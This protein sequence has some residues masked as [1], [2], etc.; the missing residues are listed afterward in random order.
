MIKISFLSAFLVLVYYQVRSQTIS[1]EEQ[2]DLTLLS[3]DSLILYQFNIDNS[4]RMIY[5]IDYKNSR[6]ILP[7]ELGLVM[8]DRHGWTIP[9]WYDSL[10]YVSHSYSRTD[11]TWQPLYGEQAQIRDHFHQLT[12]RLQHYSKPEIYLEILIRAYNEGIAFAYHFPEQLKLQTIHIESE[13]TTFTLPSE[14]NLW[15]TNRAQGEYEQISFSEWKLPS[16]RPLTVVLPSG[17]FAAITEA[18]LVNYSRAML[19]QKNPGENVLHMILDSPVIETSPFTTPWRVIMLGDR[20][21][22]LLDNNYLLLNLND[23]NKIE[24]TEWIRP[25]KAIREMSLSTEGGLKLVDFAVQQG[26]DFIHLDAG[27]YGYEYSHLA[28]ARTVSVDPRRNPDGNLDLPKVIDYAT[29]HNIG[30]WLYVNHRE[31]EHRLDEL[32]PLYQEWG[33]SGIKFGFVQV[34]THR[35]T[36][37][38]HEAIKKCAEYELMVN[39]HDAYRPTGFS[40]TYP[41]LMTMEGI[42]GNEEMPDATHNTILP[43]TRYVA[44][45]ADYTIAYYTRKEFGADGRFIKTTPAHQLALAVIY[46]SPVQWL[47]WYD[48]PTDYQDEP[49]TEFFAQVPTVWDQSIVVDG[50]I[51]EF[52]VSA[53]MKGNDWYIGAITNDEA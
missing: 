48:R 3:P 45:P 41:N 10:E 1:R 24:N 16:E 42:R 46:Y 43:F 28:D 22:D 32:L 25:G 39:V 5:Q 35:W 21:G 40:R 18:R 36:T 6:V 47:Y 52:I 11:T 26:L 33:I 27:W 20:P 29:A 9:D 37:W 50:Q 12:V 13:L 23:P 34:G 31:L 7:S 49:E 15:H 51:G 30:V 2:P 53:R 38:L 8:K 4:G 44:G 19:H 14:S 17:A